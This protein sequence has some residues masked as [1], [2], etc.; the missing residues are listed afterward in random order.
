MNKFTKEELIAKNQYL[1]NKLLFFESLQQKI[2]YNDSFLSLLLD[3]IPSPVFY[4]NVDGIYLHCNNAFSKTILG[5]DK[6][7][8]IGKSLYD[9]PEYIPIELANTYSNKDEELFTN[10]GTQFYEAKVKCADGK[11]KFFNFYKATFL[12]DNNDVLGLVGIMLDVTAYKNI[13]KELQEKNKK[14][15][16]LSIIDDLTNLYNR[17]YFENIYNQKLSDLNRTNKTF[18]FALIDIDFF[19]DYNDGFGHLEGDNTLKKI[20]LILKNTFNRI[21]DYTFRIGGEEFGVLFDVDNIDSSI[22]MIQ[23]L[24]LNIK[25]SKIRTYNTSV[26]DYITV[27]IGLG[28]ISS[29]KEN[30]KRKREQIYEEVDHQMYKSKREGRDR[31]K[32][33]EIRL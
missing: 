33:V 32:I 17:R 30:D 7:K 2:D 26:S 31:Y 1:E 13:E 11:I 16:E 19:K 4:K 10:P 23:K 14:L 25:E 28:Y 22:K 29:Y 3:T 24:M 8:I 21:N 18:A 20:A 5:I 27:S 9:L 6:E 15:E 12:S